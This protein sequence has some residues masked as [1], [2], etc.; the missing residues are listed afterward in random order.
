MHVRV[1]VCLLACLRPYAINFKL[2]H[3]KV[4]QRLNVLGYFCAQ[5]AV[6]EGLLPER[7]IGVKEPGAM[8]TQVNAFMATA[9]HDIQGQAVRRR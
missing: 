4:S 8:T 5:P 3:L 1:R 2:A 6:G 7:S 9:D